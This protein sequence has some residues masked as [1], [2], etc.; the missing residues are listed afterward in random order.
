MAT[1]F[2][3]ETPGLPNVSEG[4]PR[5]L[6]NT[7]IFALDGLVTAGLLYGPATVGVGTYEWI[8]WR[9]LSPTT[10]TIVGQQLFPS[11]LP[12]VWNS[13]GTLSSIINVT[14][15]TAYRYGVRTSDGR[16]AATGAL[17]LA[18]G[19]TNGNITAP[20]TGTNPTG[21]GNLDN[22]AF[23]TDATS[24]PAQTF[25]GNGYFVDL[26]F[27]PASTPVPP[28]PTPTPTPAQ[29]TQ[30]WNGLLG[31][32]D[33]ARQDARDQARLPE[34]ACPRDGEPFRT[35]VDGIV[36]CPYDGYQPKRGY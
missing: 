15:N 19:I 3:A 35:N 27:T 25:N 14:A 36:Y 21:I 6:A 5:T 23:A 11:V 20:Q 34:S 4:A 28:D 26:D 22:G 33:T 2:S 29:T 9:M 31:L 13:T 24:F 17:F 7:V 10:G 32:I 12:G 1:L 16:Y 8:M 18:A 30:G